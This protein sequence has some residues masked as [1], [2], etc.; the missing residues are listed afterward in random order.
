[1]DV[2]RA[3]TENSHTWENPLVGRETLGASCGTQCGESFVRSDVLSPS[4]GMRVDV[5]LLTGVQCRW[6]EYQ[7]PT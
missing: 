4:W 1:M 6:S 3:E 7:W 2:G 5:V